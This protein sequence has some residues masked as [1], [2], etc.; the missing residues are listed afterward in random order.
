MEA[1]TDDECPPTA[2]AL[3]HIFAVAV[4]RS[5]ELAFQVSLGSMD[6]LWGEGLESPKQSCLPSEVFQRSDVGIA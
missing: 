5:T 1:F 4:T 2:S 3:N 6:V